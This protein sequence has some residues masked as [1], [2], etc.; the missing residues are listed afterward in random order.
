MKQ[1]QGFSLIEVLLAVVV[2]AIGLLAGSR[3]Q[4]LGTIFSIASGSIASTR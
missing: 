1:Q 3:M 2:L 4:M